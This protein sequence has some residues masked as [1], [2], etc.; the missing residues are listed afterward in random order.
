MGHC[1]PFFSLMLGHVNLT[2]NT[3]KVSSEI[4]GRH[5]IQKYTRAKRLER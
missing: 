1:A 3:V 4:N 5:V 2:R